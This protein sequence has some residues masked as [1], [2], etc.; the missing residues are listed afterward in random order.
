MVVILP[1]VPGQSV[2]NLAVEAI[3]SEPGVVPH[4]NHNMVAPTA[5]NL[6]HRKNGENARHNLVQDILNLVNGQLVQNHV[7]AVSK[8]EQG[9]AMHPAGPDVWTVLTWVKAT[10]QGYVKLNIVQSMETGE[11]GLHGEPAQRHVG[12]VVA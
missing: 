5:Q 12:Q 10:K 4:P 3:N 8:K 9:F 11:L 7:E 6:G 2:P 1:S